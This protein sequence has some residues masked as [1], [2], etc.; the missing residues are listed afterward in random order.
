VAKQKEKE[1]RVCWTI[2]VW[3]KS[4]RAAAKQALKIQRDP[5]SIA[6]HF[7]VQMVGGRIKKDSEV[8]LG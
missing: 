8:D 6:T 3:A 2:E 7:R 4:P 1:Y 5:D